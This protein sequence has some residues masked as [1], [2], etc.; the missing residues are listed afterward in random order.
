MPRDVSEQD[1]D[2]ALPEMK[3]EDMDYIEFFEAVSP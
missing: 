3:L 1:F 2:V